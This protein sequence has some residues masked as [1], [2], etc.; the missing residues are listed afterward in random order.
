LLWRPGSSKGGRNGLAFPLGAHLSARL[1]QAEASALIC[2]SSLKGTNA[3]FCADAGEIL[4]KASSRSKRVP[5][6]PCANVNLNWSSLRWGVARFEGKVFP[7]TTESLDGNWS[8][9]SA[10]NPVEKPARTGG[11]GRENQARNF[12]PWKAL[13]A[14]RRE[15]TRGMRLRFSIGTFRTKHQGKLIAR[16]RRLDQGEPG[17]PANHVTLKESDLSF[18]NSGGGRR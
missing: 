9:G 17:G 7:R 13:W 16:A 4:D 5:F 10:V 14:R 8:Q 2:S 3:R 18:R 6:V 15:P 1:R 12:S 11:V